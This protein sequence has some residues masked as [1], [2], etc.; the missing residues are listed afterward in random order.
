MTEA[1]KPAVESAPSAEAQPR[2]GG[3]P[4]ARRMLISIVVVCLVVIAGIAALLFYLRPTVVPD[5]RGKD[6]PTATTMLDDMVLE[7]GERGEVATSAVGSGLVV[8]QAPAPGAKASR[9][10]SVDVTL[11]VTP[12]S[13]SVPDVVGKSAEEAQSVLSDAL[14]LPV[15]VAV[16]GVEAATG[17]VVQQQ[18][19]PGSSW[20]TGQ[21][22]A[23]AVSAGADNG[24]AVAVPD[25]MDKSPDAALSALEAEG[26]VGAGL[27]VDIANPEANELVAQLPAA[28]TLVDPGTTVLMLFK[29]P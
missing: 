24:T 15:T 26:L 9:H 3:D 12:V 22:V 19:V 14:F 27:V 2:E 13:A 10:S 21:R 29:A 20:M 18:P 5:V 7:V 1:E 8:S 6:L 16:Y 28:G 11:A 23:L 17:T 25:L 4:I